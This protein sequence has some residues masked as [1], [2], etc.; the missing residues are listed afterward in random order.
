MSINFNGGTTLKKEML[1]IVGAIGIFASMVLLFVAGYALAKSSE[2]TMVSIF[3][4]FMAF[5][6]LYLGD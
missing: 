6:M 4:W 5:L 1:K 3:V 2:F